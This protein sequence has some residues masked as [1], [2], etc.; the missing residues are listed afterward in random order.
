MKCGVCGT[1]DAFH[2]AVRYLCVNRK[3]RQY[4]EEWATEVAIKKRG[5]SRSNQL[6]LEIEELAQEP[7][8]LLD[9]SYHH[10]GGFYSP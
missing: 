1:E 6:E 9:P 4:D 5:Q 10:L 3:C 2:F 8:D 7:D